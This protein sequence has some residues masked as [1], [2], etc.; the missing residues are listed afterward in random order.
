MEPNLNWGNYIPDIIELCT[1]YLL[2][3]H[4]YIS[5]TLIGHHAFG[6]CF[7]NFDLQQPNRPNYH[8]WVKER[9]KKW[10]CTCWSQEVWKLQQHLSVSSMPIHV[11]QYV[12][13]AQK[14]PC[15]H[16]SFGAYVQKRRVILCMHNQ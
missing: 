11:L 5:M 14:R 6:C 12:I 9:L 8:D 4:R 13:H 3:K 7:G 1:V 15:T 16:L 2:L 10:Q